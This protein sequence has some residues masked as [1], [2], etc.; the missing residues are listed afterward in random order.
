LTEFRSRRYEGKVALVTGGGSGIGRAIAMRL[1]GEGADVVLF[2]L[3][4]SALT[5]TAEVIS[6]AGPAVTTVV[7][8]VADHAA[9]AENV[10]RVLQDK[11]RLDWAREDSAQLLNPA[12][13]VVDPQLAIDRMKGAK[14]LRGRHR[15]AAARL[16]AW[17]ESEALRANR[18]RQWIAKDSQLL[19]I[20]NQLPATFACHLS[21][22]RP[23][24]S[25]ITCEH[26]CP[27]LQV[28]TVETELFECRPDEFQ[29]LAVHSA[30]DTRNRLVPQCPLRNGCLV[31]R[32][33]KIHDRLGDSGQPASGG[34][35]ADFW[36]AY[37]YAGGVVCPVIE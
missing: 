37:E 18:P 30:G 34:E 33:I 32:Q 9:V 1:A 19:E 31:T 12:L 7:G 14:N 35:S 13:Y 23:L 21:K 25:H 10:G 8:D 16:A 6:T 27:H 20:A 2:D 4:A 17:R 24:P 5:E 22:H 29:P 36:V 3:D 28:I 11:G 26:P 15:A